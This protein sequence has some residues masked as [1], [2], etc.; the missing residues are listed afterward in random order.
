MKAQLDTSDQ[1]PVN[2]GRK[3]PPE[4]LTGDE[5]DALIAACSPVSRTGIRNRAL[6]SAPPVPKPVSLAPGRWLGMWDPPR[7]GS[8][9]QDLDTSQGGHLDSP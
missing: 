7:F 9:L 2:K 8:D 6:L 3:F 1:A 5:A 4:P